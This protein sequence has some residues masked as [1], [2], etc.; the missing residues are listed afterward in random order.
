[1]RGINP[2]EF[3]LQQEK[4]AFFV[5]NVNGGSYKKP[6]KVDPMR[7][8]QSVKKN[9]L[10]DQTGY[11]KGEDRSGDVNLLSKDQE[12][13][14]SSKNEDEEEVAGTDNFKSTLEMSQTQEEE[15]I[16]EDLMMKGKEEQKEIFSTTSDMRPKEKPLGRTK[17]T[18]QQTLEPRGE[19]KGRRGKEEEEKSGSM[20]PQ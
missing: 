12:L 18:D 8:S 9:M 7:I 11:M 10:K 1:V 3:A 6:K 15:P 20:M 14:F 16:G 2:E 13:N 5:P 4:N 19:E 17:I